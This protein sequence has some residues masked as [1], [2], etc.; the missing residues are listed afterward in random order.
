[1]VPKES[2]KVR[3]IYPQLLKIIYRL[4]TQLVT[5]KIP[6]PIRILDHC[7]FFEIRAHCNLIL[8]S[9]SSYLPVRTRARSPTRRLHTQCAA[10]S[11]VDLLEGTNEA[12]LA[13]LLPI[14]SSPLS[15]VRGGEVLPPSPVIPTQLLYFAP[16]I[17]TGQPGTKMKLKNGIVA[18][19][20]DLLIKSCS[21]SICKNTHQS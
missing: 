20:A 19:H 21:G 10:S 6:I 12:L 3:I 5:K 18:E 13:G 8:S 9:S 14:S 4:H 17:D 16:S 7:I 11:L 1:M 2:L 15:Q